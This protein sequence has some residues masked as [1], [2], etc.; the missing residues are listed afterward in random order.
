L[1]TVDKFLKIANQQQPIELEAKLEI[2]TESKADLEVV[3][4]TVIETKPERLMCS[5]GDPRW[6]GT[7]EVGR[8]SEVGRS[9]KIKRRAF[10]VDLSR[11]RLPR[12]INKQRRF[13]FIWL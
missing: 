6:R 10:V 11:H 9:K 1:I 4:S 7:Q 13:H 2:I 8:R 12:E 3:A 5:F